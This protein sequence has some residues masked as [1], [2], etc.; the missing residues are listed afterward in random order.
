[1]LK[2]LFHELLEFK[3]NIKEVFMQERFYGAFEEH[4]KL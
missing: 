4:M 1:M 3:V 2:D